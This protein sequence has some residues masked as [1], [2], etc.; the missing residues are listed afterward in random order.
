MNN[1]PSTSTPLA[2]RTPAPRR[3][4]RRGLLGRALPAVSCL[5][6]CVLLGAAAAA[7]GGA[8]VLVLAGWVAV[9][10]IVGLRVTGG[11]DERP[12]GPPELVLAA[13]GHDG[14]VGPVEQS[15]LLVPTSA[16]RA[17]LRA[18]PRG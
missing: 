5:I 14:E 2:D 18:R 9:L 15:L 16:A 6:A 8:A 11:R 17:V 4:A 12:A 3:N 1:P 10:V 7:D 13:L